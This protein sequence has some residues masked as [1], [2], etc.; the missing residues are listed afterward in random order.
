M[1]IASVTTEPVREEAPREACFPLPE[2]HRVCR[3]LLRRLV[4]HNTDIQSVPLG[5]TMLSMHSSYLHQVHDLSIHLGLD[6]PWVAQRLP[7]VIRPRLFRVTV[8]LATN[9]SPRQSHV[10]EPVGEL[11][12]P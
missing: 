12:S 4:M 9:S 3:H 6:A 2:Q 8:M 11:F 7:A 5:T 10:L 1:C